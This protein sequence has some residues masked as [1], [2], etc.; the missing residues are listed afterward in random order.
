M[1]GKPLLAAL[2]IVA[3]LPGHA[4]ATC[5]V[6]G[7]GVVFGAYD[8]FQPAPTDSTGT[9][10]YHCEGRDKDI[11]ISISSGSSGAVASRTLQ[12]PGDVLG[13]NLF[14]DAG[15]TQIWGDGSGG[16]GTYFVHNPQNNQDVVLTVF[17][18]IPAAQDPSVGA[19]SDTVVV[20]IDY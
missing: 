20:T 10:T 8:V 13:Y 1:N 11:R 4:E 5:T 15:F 7:S 2:A 3:A 17:G 12:Q 19:Y 6:S 18:R 14:L 16:T 9:I